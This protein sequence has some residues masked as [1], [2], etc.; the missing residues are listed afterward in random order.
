MQKAVIVYYYSEKKNHL[1]EL[2]KLLQEGW[3]V[4]S[5]NASG[6]PMVY[7]LVIVEKNERQHSGIY[8]K[9]RELSFNQTAFQWWFS[10]WHKEKIQTEYT[11]TTFTLR[12]HFGNR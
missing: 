7:S 3:K 4:V 1:N 2:N 12:A 9:S 5:Q 8:C 10:F 6:Y 11:L